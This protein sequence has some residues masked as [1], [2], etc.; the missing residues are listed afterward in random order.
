MSRSAK[1]SL[2]KQY[3]LIQEKPLYCWKVSDN[4]D[5]SKFV[6]KSYNLYGTNFTHPEYRFVFDFGNGSTVTYVKPSNIDKFVNNK[7][8]SFIDDDDRAFD[9]IKLSIQN[10]I[11]SHQQSVEKY[12]KFFM[13]VTGGILRYEENNS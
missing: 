8:Y 6:I 4:G 3:N 5:V 1:N 12:A 7:V 9:I 2:I 10:K 11:I 13:D